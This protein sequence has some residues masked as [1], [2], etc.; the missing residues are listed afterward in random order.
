MVGAAPR[1]GLAISIVA[2]LAL[3][4]HWCA[5]WN[6]ID[7]CL[8]AGHVY[9]YAHEVCDTSALT[10]PVISYV[11]R[12][13]NLIRLA[14]ALMLAGAALSGY[15]M[16]RRIRRIPFSLV[17]AVLVMC[18]AVWAVPGWGRLV[19]VAPVLAGAAGAFWMLRHSGA[20]D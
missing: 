19:L 3:G 10:L 9:D 7:S 1:A 6:A 12:H 17:M 5:D 16:R 4:A 14:W 8:D 13:S 15:V 2:G 18:L 11:D 20:S